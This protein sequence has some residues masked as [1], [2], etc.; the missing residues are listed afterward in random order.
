MFKLIKA[1]EFVFW[2]LYN[3]LILI[4]AFLL[5]R[6][7]QMLVFVLLF[8]F[9]HNAFNYRFHSDNVEKDP[10]KAVRLCKIITIIIEILFL[11]FCKELD[12]SLYSNLFIIMCICLGNCF[13]GFIIVKIYKYKECPIRK[14]IK[15][16]KLI[17]MCDEKGLNELEKSIMV[18]YYCKGYKLDK[19]AIDRK[20]V[21]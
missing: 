7:L 18:D 17:T 20:S 4:I 16:D 21:V 13:L 11:I 2:L 15:E 8:N 6:F 19:I 1:R 12:V 5:E 10:I 9:F 3:I 14:G